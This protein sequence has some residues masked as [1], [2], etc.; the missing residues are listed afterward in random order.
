MSLWNFFL[1]SAFQDWTQTSSFIVLIHSVVC[2]RS[3]L[4]PKSFLQ[5]WR[6]GTRAS[7]VRIS[8]CRGRKCRTRSGV[9]GPVSHGQSMVGLGLSHMDSRLWAYIAWAVDCGPVSHGQSIVGIPHL[10]WAVGLCAGLTWAFSCGPVSHGQSTVGLSH[11][12]S[13]LWAYLTRAV[14]C[15]L[16]SSGQSIV[17]D[18]HRFCLSVCLT[19]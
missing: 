18:I 15:G 1:S 14:D 4:K 11:M 13:R 17:V 8:L 5:T 10:T 2:S 9:C 6:L 19:V 12:D 16:V 3:C 7:C